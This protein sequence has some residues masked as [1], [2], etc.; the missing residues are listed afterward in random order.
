M[1]DGGVATHVSLSG[2][3]EQRGFASGA[4]LGSAHGTAVASLISGAGMIGGPAQGA[5]L[6]IADVYGTDRSGG[7]ALAIARALGWLVERRAP[8]VTMSLVGPPNVLLERAVRLAQARGTTLVAAVGNDGAAAPPS[9]PASYPAVIAVTAVDRRNHVLLEAGRS[10]HVEF[11]APGS[12]MAA[13]SVSGGG[14]TV[15]GTSFAAPLVAALAWR[16]ITAGAKNPMPV[17]SRLAVDLGPPGV[18]RIYG[19][20]LLCGGCRSAPPK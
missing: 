16:A 19:F 9:Y 13:A 15:R 3:V 1:I 14:S 6:L 5:P 8:V 18:D 7:N 12:D 10:L 4:P 2:P 20:G 17:L 11:A